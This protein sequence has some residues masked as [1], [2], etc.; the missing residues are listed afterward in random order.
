MIDVNHLAKLANMK[1]SQEEAKKLEKG[2]TE[3]L[4]SVDLLNKLDT[5]GVSSSFQVTGL[6]NIF[7]EDKIN[8]EKTFTQEQALSSAKKTFKGY[9][10]VPS[11][12]S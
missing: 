9:F 7:R 3:S 10:L 8:T 5:K 12:F 2:F 1:V 6:K 11:V 4:K